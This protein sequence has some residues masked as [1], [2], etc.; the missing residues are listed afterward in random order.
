MKRADGV[1][2]ESGLKADTA[3]TPAIEY[4]QTYIHRMWLG[5]S[6]LCFFEISKCCGDQTSVEQASSGARSW[7]LCGVLL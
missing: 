4:I 5:I 6:P 1:D 2:C 3:T 7:G